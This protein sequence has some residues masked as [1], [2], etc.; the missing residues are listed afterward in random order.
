MKEILKALREQKNIRFD[1]YKKGTSLAFW[2]MLEKCEILIINNKLDLEGKMMID[3][4]TADQEQD[5]LLE[6]GYK[7]IKI[8]DKVIKQMEKI[9][10]KML[11]KALGI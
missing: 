11:M 10:K 4:K 3:E 8:D 9:Q 5:N 2:I 7:P 1:V 6:Q